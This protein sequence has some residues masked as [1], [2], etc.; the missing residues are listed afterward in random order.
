MDFDSKP[1]WLENAIKEGKKMVTV[2]VI[3]KC[4]DTLKWYSD[5]IGEVFDLVREDRQYYYARE[6]NGGYL[7]VIDKND[8]KKV[9]LNVDRLH[10]ASRS[11]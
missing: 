5:Y 7:N 11:Q 2:V 10:Y 8:A 9:E 1:Y 3:Q 4:P 6:P